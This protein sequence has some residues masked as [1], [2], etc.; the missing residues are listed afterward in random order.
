MNDQILMTMILAFLSPGVCLI[1]FAGMAQVM[2]YARSHGQIW[3]IILF[4]LALGGLARVASSLR[5]TRK[6]R[7]KA[8]NEQPM[9]EPCY[10]VHRK[11]DGY[12]FT[13]NH[14]E[15][16]ECLRKGEIEPGAE[17]FGGGFYFSNGGDFDNVWV[18]AGH[19]PV[20]S[21]DV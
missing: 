8:Q 1:L 21:H 19:R 15:Y 3:I 11:A 14:T 17:P 4:G 9:V 2:V 16:E 5:G 10:L 20:R 13:V 12:P 6:H 18:P 7:T